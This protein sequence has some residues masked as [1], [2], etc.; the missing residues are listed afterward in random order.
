ME[1]HQGAKVDNNIELLLKRRSVRQFTGELISKEIVKELLEAAMA[2]PSARNLN[3]W[4]FTVFNG[5]FCQEVVP[6]LSNGKVLVNAN[7]GILVCTDVENACGGEL[8]YAIQDCSAAIQNILLAAS[9]KGLGTCW[10][11]VHPRTQRVEKCIE[12]FS[13]PKTLTP[14]AVISIGVPK[15][16]AE[17]R[18]RYSEEKVEWLTD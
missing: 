16:T 5:D 9:M 12:L 10:M 13:L 11:G 17:P 4:H 15:V 8:S 18:T 14:I 7:N 3:P 6:A 1:S 2:A